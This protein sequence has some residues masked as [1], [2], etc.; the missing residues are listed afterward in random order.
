MRDVA[1][2]REGRA[3]VDM[4][5]AMNSPG[6]SIGWISAISENI[7]RAKVTETPPRTKDERPLA[8]GAE[9][10]GLKRGVES[11]EPVRTKIV[12]NAT[13]RSKMKKAAQD[14]A[15]V[16]AGSANK[17]DKAKSCPRPVDV[18]EGLVL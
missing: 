3:E 4:V 15:R 18:L 9:E 12:W 10:S 5:L 16:V 8:R 14:Q 6:G 11:T 13:E 17:A 7:R 2:P 1:S